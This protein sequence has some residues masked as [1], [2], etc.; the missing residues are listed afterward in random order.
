VAVITIFSGSFCGGAEV[1]AA[2][3]S[4]LGYEYVESQLLD[5]AAERFGVARDRLVRTLEGPPPFLSK[6]THEREKNLAALRAAIADLILRDNVVYHG[7]AGHLVPGGISH[8]LSVCVVANLPYRIEMAARQA[9]LSE[10]QAV[11]TIH[12]DDGQRL[13][14]TRDLRGR[15][16]YDEGLYDLLLAMQ[17][18]TVESAV[19][20]VCDIAR[21]EEL[22]TTSESRQAAEDFILASRVEIALAPKGYAVEVT[23][24]KGKATIALNQYVSRLDSVKRQLESVAAETPGVSG[25]LC[26]PGPGYVPPSLLGPTDEFEPPS[27]I[28]LVDDEREFVHTLSERL[29]ARNLESAVVYDGEE[30]L[31][32]V[33]SDEPE[34]MVLDLKM[35]GIDGI[36]VLRRV[37]QDHP[38]VEV[39]ILTGHGSKKEEETAMQLGA[40]AYLRKPVDIELLTSTMKQAYRKIGKPPRM[41]RPPTEE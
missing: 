14:W 6:L 32:F 3:A 25:A 35:P 18:A 13:R 39:I 10:R 40:F 1:A 11:K 22:R 33:A 30:A 2:V 15:D 23:C 9:G 34:V 19:Q 36:E 29:Q 20:S 8:V 12:R 21:G 38:A 28:L 4:S 7:F 5:D 16:P 31:T 24:S 27:K 37:K 26:V 17:S 41:G